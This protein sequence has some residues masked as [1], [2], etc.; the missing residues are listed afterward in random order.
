MVTPEPITTAEQ[1]LQAPDLG[2]CEL[3][4]GK[5]VQGTYSSFEAGRIAASLAVDL[6]GFVEP[7]KL[8]AVLIGGPGCQIAHDPDTVR[9]P[10]IA[11]VRAERIPK[12]NLDGFLQGAPDLAV[13]ILSH[14]DLASEVL[15]KVLDWLEAGCRTVWVVDPETKTVSVYRS[16]TEI[17]V[18]TAADTLTGGDVLPGFSLPVNE[19]FP[20]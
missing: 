11:F 6:A 20:G 19:I 15:A 2:P 18:L 14:S 5:L 8:G 4:R 16:R 12:Q 17:A 7:R 1:L 3:V 13:E 9:A 10:D